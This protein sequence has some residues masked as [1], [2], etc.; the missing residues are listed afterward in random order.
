MNPYNLDDLK[1]IEHWRDFFPNITQYL[2]YSHDQAHLLLASHK[3][4]DIHTQLKMARASLIY[5]E[6][7]NYGQLI[8]KHD[9]T[10]LTF[11]RSKFLFDALSLYNYCI[12]LSWQMVYLYHGDA[13]FGVVQFEEYYLQASKDCNYESLQGRLVK[14]NKKKSL[15]EK[16]NSFFNDDLT[17]EVRQTYN[18][19]KHRG[20]YHIE[21][22]GVNQDSVPI[23]LNGHKLKMIKR[24]SISI[25]Q[26]KEKLIQFDTFFTRYFEEILSTLMPKEFKNSTISLETL[27]NTAESLREWERNQNDL[28]NF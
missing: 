28:N 12:D 15:F 11:I 18:Y 14:V 5:L 7:E 23:D 10:H 26:E 25:D 19:I 9:T 21:G 22:L 24:K 2:K 27:L 13:H 4:E 6:V 16:I 17:K 8:G 3:I 1:D 20:T